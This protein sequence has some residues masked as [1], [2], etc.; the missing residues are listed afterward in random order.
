[1]ES[2]EFATE[3]T[4]EF[5]YFE[6]RINKKEQIE[7]IVRD[8]DADIDEA[9]QVI[10]FCNKIVI[11]NSRR[12]LVI[13]RSADLQELVPITPEQITYNDPGNGVLTIYISIPEEY[14]QKNWTPAYRAQLASVPDNGDTKISNIEKS[15]KQILRWC[16]DLLN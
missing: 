2:L 16:K 1:M 3:G 12:S 11:A 15:A 13:R 14:K 7:I 6:A 5:S 4:P 10:I 8:E 9:Y